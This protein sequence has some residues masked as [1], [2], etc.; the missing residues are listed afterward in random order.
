MSRCCELKSLVE[1]EV[2]VCYKDPGVNIT[3]RDTPEHITKTILS[4][5][6]LKTVM[7]NAENMINKKPI[8]KLR[9]DVD[10]NEVCV[11]NTSQLTIYYYCMVAL[12]CHGVICQS[13]MKPHLDSP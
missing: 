11:M 5:D 12:T 8:T 9:D 7:C 1:F 10:D 3:S 4:D 2:A 13:V 6:K